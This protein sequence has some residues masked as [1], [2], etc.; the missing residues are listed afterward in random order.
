[1]SSVRSKGYSVFCPY[2]FKKDIRFWKES[3]LTRSI[4]YFI[5][6]VVEGLGW[7]KTTDSPLKTFNFIL[8]ISIKSLSVGQLYKVITYSSALT[9]PATP[10]CICSCVCVSSQRHPFHPLQAWWTPRGS[11]SHYLL[12]WTNSC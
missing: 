1:M 10:L 7:F 5:L 12:Q 3:L 11:I 6:T 2:L 4:K 8:N 9:D